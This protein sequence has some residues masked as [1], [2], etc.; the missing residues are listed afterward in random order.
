MGKRK[1][2]MPCLCCGRKLTADS[3]HD[4]DYDASVRNWR[5]GTGVAIHCGWGS[6]FDGGSYHGVICDDCI[7]KAEKRLLVVE[8]VIHRRPEIT[9]AAAPKSPKRKAARRAR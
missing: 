9:Y 3:E 4:H 2:T 1:T 7:A 8:T 5:D 6:G